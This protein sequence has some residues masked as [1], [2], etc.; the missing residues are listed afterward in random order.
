MCQSKLLFVDTCSSRDKNWIASTTRTRSG[1]E[2][3][4]KGC[5][6]KKFSGKALLD[7]KDPCVSSCQ[8]SHMD[9]QY[10]DP[11]DGK[12]ESLSY[13][14]GFKKKGNT[15]QR[16]RN[17]VVASLKGTSTYDSYGDQQLHPYYRLVKGIRQFHGEHRLAPPLQL[18]ERLTVLREG[19]SQNDAVPRKK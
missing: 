1:L 17:S 6:D 9:Q 4:W 16:Y 10:R 2:P 15:N 13:A 12:T 11:L 5:V 19:L 8:K 18:I 3:S 14:V 7:R